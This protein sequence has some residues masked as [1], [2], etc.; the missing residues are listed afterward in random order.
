MKDIG[1]R[2][3]PLPS[4]PNPL[5][6]QINSNHDSLANGLTQPTKIPMIAIKAVNNKT[7]SKLSNNNIHKALNNSQWSEIKY[8]ISS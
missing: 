8:C 2:T 7:R 3:R 6:S 1:F 4:S 5:I